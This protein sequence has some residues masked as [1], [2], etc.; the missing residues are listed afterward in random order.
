[1]DQK[2]VRFV[3]TFF[4]DNKNLLV[5]QRNE[6][7]AIDP[8]KW[9]LPSTTLAED[10]NYETALVRECKE[11]LGLNIK[12]IQ[13]VGSVEIDKKDEIYL[14]MFILVEGDSS[15]L[16]LKNHKEHKF[17]SYDEYKNLDM[18]ESNKQFFKAFDSE[19]KQYID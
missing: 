6:N 1:M 19:I 2:V 4:V 17:I 5:A 12:I 3:A 8:L 15:S 11:E 10:D 14:T 16:T 13:E 18:R 9:E 7:E